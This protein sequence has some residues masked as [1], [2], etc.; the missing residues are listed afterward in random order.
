MGVARHG[1]D[2]AANPDQYKTRLCKFWGRLSRQ[3]LVERMQ[4]QVVDVLSDLSEYEYTAAGVWLDGHWHH[5]GTA[6]A[7]ILWH[8]QCSDRL[9][10][11]A[12]DLH[13]RAS[14]RTTQ[15]EDSSRCR[16]SLF[17]SIIAS[18]SL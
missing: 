2:A 4:R 15:E 8:L 3:I 7:R 17:L 11:A 1:L 9:V 13:R 16:G 12:L 18:T 6:M 14:G 5:N 10:S